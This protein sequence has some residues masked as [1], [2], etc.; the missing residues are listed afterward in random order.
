MV[1]MAWDG[2]DEPEGIGYW[3]E[4]LCAR[5]ICCIVFRCSMTGQ[6]KSDLNVCT[7]KLNA[8]QCMH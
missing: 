1:R 8:L 3:Y 5:G 4:C 2:V 6:E 7:R